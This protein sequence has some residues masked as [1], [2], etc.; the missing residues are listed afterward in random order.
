MPLT[1][2]LK[3]LSFRQMT[4]LVCNTAGRDLCGCVVVVFA[5]R[6]DSAGQR[7]GC[8]CQ[9]AKSSWLPQDNMLMV[10]SNHLLCSNLHC[11]SDLVRQKHSTSFSAIGYQ[12]R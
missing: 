1:W 11:F 10:S 8:C 9:H 6:G 2:K 7:E 12:G 5:A 3:R 4:N